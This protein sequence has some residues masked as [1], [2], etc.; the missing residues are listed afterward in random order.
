MELDTLRFGSGKPGSLDELD[1][2]LRGKASYTSDMNLDQQCHAVFLRS[3]YAHGRIVRI[4]TAA[5][6]AMPGVKALITG[7]DLQAAGWGLIP[8][9]A[10]FNDKNG[11]P[12][13]SRAM[14]PL[15]LDHVRYVGEALALVIADSVE[16][17]TAASEAVH[18]EIESLPATSCPMD[19]LRPS[20]PLVHHDLDSNL[21][22]HWADGDLAQS[23]SIFSQADHVIEVELED[24]PVAACALE[25]RSA[26]AWWDAQHE[27]YTLIAPTQGVM[28]VRKLL[29]ENVLKVPLEKL[30]VLTPNVGGGFGAKVQ[31]YAE[32][33]AL[34]FA[35][36]K[37]GRPVKW[38]AGRVESFLTDTHGRNSHLKARMAFDKTGK[39]LGLQAHTVV[40][41]GAYSSTYV[42]IV[43][44]NNTKNCLSSVYRIPSIYME[45]ELVFT[46]AMPLGPYRGAGRPE[47]ILMIER[48]IEKAAKALAIDSVALR[49]RN[50]IAPSEM[51]Y[52]AP[53]GQIYD[54][55]EFEAVMDKALKLSDW[56]GFAARRRLSASKGKLRGIGMC[57]FLEVAGGIL[58]EPAEIRFT[59]SNEVLIFLGAQAIGQ[60]H[61]STFTQLV[62]NR[63]GISKD[64]VRLVSGDSDAIPGIIPTVASRSTMMVG[65]AVSL[66]CDEAIERGRRIAAHLLEA[67]EGDFDFADGVYRIR[68]TDQSIP[69]LEITSRLKK[70]AAQL[71]PE[72]PHQLD[73]LAKFTSPTMSFPNGCHVSE[74]EIDPSTGEL[75]LVRHTTVDDVGVILNEDVVEG[76][77]IG[78]V[79]Q[80]LGQ[81][82]GESLR[83]DD[84]GQLLTASFMDYAI[85]RADNLPPIV[86]GHHVVP[87]RNNPLGVKGAGESGVAGSIP[88]ATN[89]ILDALS[90]GGFNGP[91]SMPFTTEKIWRAVQPSSSRETIA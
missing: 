1:E 66:A 57:C 54:S 51:P 68:G 24:P 45:S 79:A 60:G 75:E 65:S 17:A 29:A 32:Y 3:S 46:H 90:Q 12:M 67:S 9:V 14:P 48:L 89:A 36:H 91:L 5:A 16:N 20:A 31:A 62:A 30:R 47:A 33:A 2:I 59:D 87:C 64:Q 80:G 10:V 28:I 21:C 63:L 61:L 78:A 86:I 37:I 18:V 6:Q 38:L 22:M 41:I 69:I 43:A 34:L 11:V 72:I 84:S 85:P 42:A 8:A 76:Q 52:K 88:A 7:K 49:R 50:F 25:P 4:D 56:D 74:V 83:Y 53:N 35:A 81:V 73:N 55:G 13:K 39:I 58:E 19:A 82:I 77:I 70:H 27:K 15:A 71:P 44:T 26:I 40:G 23:E